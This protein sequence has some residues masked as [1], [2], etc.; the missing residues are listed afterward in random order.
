[1]PYLPGSRSNWNF[2]FLS[3]IVLIVVP[4][5]ATIASGT[6]FLEVVSMTLPTSLPFLAAPAGDEIIARMSKT[7][8]IPVATGIGL[9]NLLIFLLSFLSDQ[10]IIGAPSRGSPDMTHARETPSPPCK[11]I[12]GQ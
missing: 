9:D 3:V 4:W 1:M 5:I 12:H 11:A 2:P 7:Q 8:K 10:S 6:G